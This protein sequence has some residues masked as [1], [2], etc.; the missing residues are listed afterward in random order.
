MRNAI[1]ETS[2]VQK[3]LFVCFFFL[4]LALHPLSAAGLESP[5]VDLNFTGE[6]MSA[7]LKGVSLGIILERIKQE[8]GIWFK[9]DTSLL[10]EKVAVQFSGLTIERGLKRILASKNYSFFYDGNRKL[11]GVI[12]ID[13]SGD[14]STAKKADTVDSS[15]KNI[16]T[17][18]RAKQAEIM[19]E[20]GEVVSAS[21]PGS[22]S[23]EKVDEASEIFG[24]V[25]DIAPH[26]GDVEASEDDLED[27]KVIKNCPPP[28]D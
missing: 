4:L 7:D 17:A 12:I 3:T 9:A 15:E 10:E 16:P 1:N 21:S 14:R 27:F 8:K 18:G 26:E 22:T 19:V 28:C 5:A 2:V 6:T 24:A 20:P 23:A 25:E 11:V 13:G